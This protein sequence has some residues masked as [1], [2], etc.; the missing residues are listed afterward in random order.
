MYLLIN[1]LTCFVLCGCSQAYGGSVGSELTTDRRNFLNY[2]VK[3]ITDEFHN[4]AEFDGVL[5]ILKCVV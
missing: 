1:D 4:N 3:S 2:K 5:I